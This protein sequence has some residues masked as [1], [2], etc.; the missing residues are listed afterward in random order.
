M[1]FCFKVESIRSLSSHC[2]EIN[3]TWAQL[4]IKALEQRLFK[5]P[6]VGNCNI[7]VASSLCSKPFFIFQLGAEKKVFIWMPAYTQL[8]CTRGGANIGI[9]PL[10]HMSEV[11]FKQPRWIPKLDGINIL[12]SSMSFQALRDTSVFIFFFCSSERA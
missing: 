12:L 11:T 9:K 5:S 4:S 8:G 2:R 3:A 10:F 1:L 6:R 7:T